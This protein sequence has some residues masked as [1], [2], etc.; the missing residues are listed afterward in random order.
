[1]SQN[2]SGIKMVFL[3]GP[4]GPQLE[5]PE[6]PAVGVA[7]SSVGNR[8]DSHFLVT[9]ESHIHLVL[10][11]RY[12]A[13]CVSDDEIAADISPNRVEFIISEMSDGSATFRDEISTQQCLQLLDCWK[14]HLAEYENPAD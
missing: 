12:P 9:L 1:M 2:E 14:R 13:A 10:S 8:T 7:L 6:C 5:T 11:G 4:N 3:D